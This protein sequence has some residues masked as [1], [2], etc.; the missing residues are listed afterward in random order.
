VAATGVSGPPGGRRRLVPFLPW[1]E[2]WAAG[3]PRPEW[4]RLPRAAPFVLLY[5]AASWALFLPT[6]RPVPGNIVTDADGVRRFFYAVPDLS[7]H[8]LRALRSLVTAPWFNHN[9]VQLAYVTV[10]LLLVGLVFEAR[11]GTG[12]FVGFFFGT[13]FAAAVVA[14]VLL[15]LL[16][17]A[18]SEA[19]FLR[20]A[21]ERPWAGGSAGCF[22]LLGATAARA[23]VPWPLLGLVVCWEANVV[24][25]YLRAEYTPA[26]HLVALSVGFLV[27]RYAVPP[28]SAGAGPRAPAPG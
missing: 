25:W 15:H 17:P 20:H 24:W 7:G 16:Y 8:P 19:T 5:L 3:R 12:R 1:A 10:L 2:A 21:W 23:R 9:L 6:A 18:L 11:E 28:R 27:A 26:F 14:G 13:S 4:R 22:G